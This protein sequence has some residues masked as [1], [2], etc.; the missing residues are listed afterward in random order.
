MED[1]ESVETPFDVN[2]KLLKLSDEKFV[3]VQSEMEGVAYN[4]GVRSLMY[5]MVA[6]TVD[7]LFAMSTVSQFMSKAGPPHWMVVKRIMRYLKAILDFKLC[8]RQ[9][10]I[11]LR[12]FVM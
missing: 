8:L 12:V 10:D 9:K 4:V 5:V 1:C 2:S 6:T 7:I 3:N 11:I